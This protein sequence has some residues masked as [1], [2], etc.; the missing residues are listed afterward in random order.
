MTEQGL[1]RVIVENVIP[2][3][4]AGRFYIKKIVGETLLVEADIFTD[5]HDIPG[6]RLLY[7]H[8][9]DKKWQFVPM[10]LINNDRWQASF[11]LQKTGFYNYKVTGWVDHALTWHHG[12]L[13]KYQDAQLM[14]IELRIGAGLLKAIVGLA[15]KQDQKLIRQFIILLNDNLK[16]DLA[17]SAVLS[18]EFYRIIEQYPDLTNATTYLR[19]LKVYVERE[20]ASFSSWYSFFPRS[21]S[22][23]EGKHGTFKDC[24]VLL[25]RIAEM[26]FDV[27]YFPADT[28]YR[29]QL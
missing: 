18:A 28:P 9:D 20:K 7:K 21:A 4:D 12:F 25:P 17:V 24:E 11:D 15:G 26:G 19:E 14:G 16:Y 6:G 27:L 23:V 29:F 5:G 13:K 3:I 2:E 8:Q 1:Q 22:P 10:Q